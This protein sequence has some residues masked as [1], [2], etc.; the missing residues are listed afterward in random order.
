[1]AFLLLSEKDRASN[2][3]SLQKRCQPDTS[4]SVQQGHD[5]SRRFRTLRPLPLARFSSCQLPKRRGAEFDTPRGA[6]QKWRSSCSTSALPAEIQTFA[7]RSPCANLKKNISHQRCQMTLKVLGQLAANI[8]KVL[9]LP[10]ELFLRVSKMLGTAPP[11][12]REGYIANSG[13]YTNSLFGSQTIK[14]GG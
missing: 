5:A 12:F 2:R 14:G 9:V 6:T 7:S 4:C 8:S 1:M 11:R 13:K 10:A 3:K